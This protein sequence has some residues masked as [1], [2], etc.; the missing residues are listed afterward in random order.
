MP[1]TAVASQIPLTDHRTL[2]AKI[3]DWF[4][5]ETRA[6]AAGPGSVEV[7]GTSITSR[8]S[9][10]G[11]FQLVGVPDG[12]VSVKFTTPD[13]EVGTLPLNLPSGGGAF[14]D[15]G[16]VVIHRSGHVEFSPSHTNDRFLSSLEARG[17]I[18]DL[19]GTVTAPPTDGSCTTFK[20]A[21][22]TFCFDQH[23]RFDPPLNAQNSLVN[24]GTTNMV[25]VVTGVPTDDIASNV[26]RA[27]RI[28]RNHG[29]ASAN[30]NTVKVIAPITNLGPNTITVFGTPPITDNDPNTPDLP[31]AH[32]VTFDTAQAKF[33]PQSLA[34]NLSKGLFVEISTPKKN[35]TSPAVTLD[36]D[37]HQV[38]T[39]DR[40]RLVRVPNPPT[41]EQLTIEGTISSL[42][43]N[44][45]TFGVNNDT[46]FVHVKDDVTRFEE[47]LT[48]FS[49]SRWDKTWTSQHPPK[50][51][52]P[53]R[54]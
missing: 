27:R 26:F 44:S 31:N 15:L 20:I 50:M 41:G 29:A 2:F 49:S 38:A 32:A 21:G 1:A 5:V 22:T 24:S 34:G 19:A 11:R 36:Q 46:V 43:P 28:Q 52:Y 7:Q 10:S 25:A 47:P 53:S 9:S 23:T 42:N 6:H 14:I 18:T 16:Q 4:V 13:G 12:A 40:V 17:P 39:A 3:T 51:W 8:P 45:K 30:N 33:D 37:G 35:G 48:S 54:L